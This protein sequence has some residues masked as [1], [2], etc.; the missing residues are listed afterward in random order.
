[1]LSEKLD[2]SGKTAV[3][4]GSSQGIGEA[5]AAIFAEHGASVVLHFHEGL[6]QAEKVKDTIDKHKGK[7]HIVQS[8]FTKPESI[9]QF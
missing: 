6:E 8:D 4:T 9:N 3:V 5:I 2:L 1:M 7:I